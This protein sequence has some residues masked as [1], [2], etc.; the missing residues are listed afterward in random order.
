MIVLMAAWNKGLRL[1]LVG[2]KEGN[3][4]LRRNFS[5]YLPE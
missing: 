3:T 4:E 5:S 2:R 1:S